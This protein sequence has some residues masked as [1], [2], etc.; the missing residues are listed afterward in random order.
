MKNLA[1]R[2]VISYLKRS[3]F[4]VLFCLA[5]WLAGL[6]SFRRRRRGERGCLLLTFSLPFSVAADDF[7]ISALRELLYCS[8]SAPPPCNPWRKPFQF[9]GQAIIIFFLC[10]RLLLLQSS[11]FLF[12]SPGCVCQRVPLSLQ[13][14]QI[15]H[16]PSKIS[17]EEEKPPEKSPHPDDDG[18][19]E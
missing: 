4:F 19:A 5:G 6:D 1:V 17:S 18:C 8:S 13:K 2:E 9:S 11:P 14:W 3:F 7:S 10:L 12:Q 15:D 16:F